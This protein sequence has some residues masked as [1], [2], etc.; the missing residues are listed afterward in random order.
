MASSPLIPALRCSD[1]PGPRPCLSSSGS[2]RGPRCVAHGRGARVKPEH[3][4]VGEPGWLPP[5]GTGQ[6][7][8]GAIS[9]HKKWPS[10]SSPAS[11]PTRWPWRTAASGTT[12]PP[13]TRTLLQ[14]DPARRHDAIGR[15]P[16]RQTNGLTSNLIAGEYFSDRKY[17]AT[18]YQKNPRIYKPSLIRESDALVQQER[19]HFDETKMSHEWDIYGTSTI[20]D[21]R[22]TAPRAK[23]KHPLTAG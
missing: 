23:L 3:D 5:G 20:N 9:H 15:L 21:Y 18:L 14:V 1:R 7:L 8:L 17:S 4:S 13:S 16:G 22:R 11:C 6:I 10:P 19:F 12:D 2:T